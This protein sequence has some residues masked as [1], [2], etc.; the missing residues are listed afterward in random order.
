[1]KETIFSTIKAAVIENAR[2]VNDCARSG[3]VNRNHV[4]YGCV[5]AYTRIL[6][7]MGHSVDVA[8]WEDGN[9]LKIPKI[10]IGPE[11]FNFPD[12]Q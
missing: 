6:R 5:V 12:G 8:V 11:V 7:D 10:T 1:M 4:N 2:H 9:F 3:D